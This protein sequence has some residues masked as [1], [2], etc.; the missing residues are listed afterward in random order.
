MREVA[1]PTGPEPTTMACCRGCWRAA[2]LPMM[3][4]SKNEQSVFM[5]MM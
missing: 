2:T 4:S 3:M 1:T 5:V